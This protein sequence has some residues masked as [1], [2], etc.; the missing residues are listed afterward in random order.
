MNQIAQNG[1][2]GFPI[3]F[4]KYGNSLRKQRGSELAIGS[5]KN[6]TEQPSYQSAHSGSHLVSHTWELTHGS[7][8]HRSTQYSGLRWLWATA[9]IT[10]VSPR[11]T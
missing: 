1:E 2:R 9:M 5:Q 8:S 3:I 11:T 7:W 6:G 10:M 4:E